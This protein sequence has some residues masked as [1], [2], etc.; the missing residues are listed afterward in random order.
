MSDPGFSAKTREDIYSNWSLVG[1]F[2]FSEALGLLVQGG[3]HPI[4]GNQ[5]SS[6]FWDESRFWPVEAAIEKALLASFILWRRRSYL[7]MSTW[8]PS[9]GQAGLAVGLGLI[10][11]YVAKMILQEPPLALHPANSV[12][13]VA[14]I[15]VLEEFF[16][17][18][19]LQRTLAERYPSAVAILVVSVVAA[20]SHQ[21]FLSALIFNIL[22]GSLYAVC[23]SSLGASS[24]CHI[25]LTATATFLRR[26][27][28]EGSETLTTT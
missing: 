2:L 25:T 1:L 14:P 23:R 28:L 15:P 12:A 19:V 13:V 11:A 27:G 26:I 24:T 16:Y 20:V 7:K 22:I 4:W 8:R 9:I 5:G 6:W 21:H 3:F 17:R 10:M 18:G